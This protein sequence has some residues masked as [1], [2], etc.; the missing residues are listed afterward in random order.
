MKKSLGAKT[1]VGVTPVW[2][3]GTYDK[4]DKPNIMAAAWDGV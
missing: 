4:V 1:I 3:V 2:I